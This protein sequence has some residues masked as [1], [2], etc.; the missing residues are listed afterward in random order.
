MVDVNL[1]N[2]AL[3]GRR[4]HTALGQKEYNRPVVLGT[5]RL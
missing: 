4:V 1:K 3:A 5:T 2:L